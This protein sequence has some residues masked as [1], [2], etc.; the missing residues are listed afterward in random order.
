MKNKPSEEHAQFLRDLGNYRQAREIYASLCAQTK[1]LSA[2]NHFN[3]LVQC[4]DEWV[5]Q[6]EASKIGEATCPIID[7]RSNLG[8]LCAVKI[9][10]VFDESN[11]LVPQPPDLLKE[12]FPLL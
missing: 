6:F 7:R 1:E 5:V 3:E 11:H 2:R 9:Q 4:L 10:R 8:C 12:A